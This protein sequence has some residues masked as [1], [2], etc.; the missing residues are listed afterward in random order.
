MSFLRL[1]NLHK[2]FN[3][4]QAVNGVNLEVKEGEFFTLLGPSGCGKT[5][6]LRL[7]GGLEEPDEGEIL[8]GDGCLVSVSRRI[9][10]NPEKRDMGMV[11]Q[12]YALWPH[13]TVFENV[14][15][16]LKLRWMKSREVRE[17]VLASLDL[18]GLAGLEDRQIPALSGGQ[19]QRV[20]LAR[21]LIFSP[22][23]LLLDEPLSN[24][25][26]QLRDEMRRELKSLQRRVG[27][28]VLFVTHDQIEALSLS[29]RIGIMSK[30]KL[31]QVGSPE[32]VYHKP[33][34][35]FAR[36]FLG[37]TFI[38]LGK[39]VKLGDMVQVE[40]HGMADTPLW[41]NQSNIPSTVSGTLRE[42][43]EVV[44]SIRPDH[45]GVSGSTPNSNRNIIHATLESV[46][47]LG[48]RYEY[49]VTMGS[50]TRVLVLPTSQVLKPGQKIFLELKAES[51][52]LW[53]RE[54]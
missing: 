13:M 2:F 38:L 34:T 49:T 22:K 4:V 3:E 8:L 30:G 33:S 24:L 11:F 15:Y 53:P 29:D 36:D 50:D 19:Q 26:A 45:I 23:V 37:K 7:V 52:S 35:T 46:H 14:A 44:V 42:G 18:V 28:T 39:V 6:T 51:L 12:S 40:P 10:V 32:E 21:A 48:D 25:D 31:E 27:V 1:Q 20:A 41:V 47:F 17:K 16:P 43:N 5:T 9:F 54:M